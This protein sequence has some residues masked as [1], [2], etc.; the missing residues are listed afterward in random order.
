MQDIIAYISEVN[1]YKIL[2]RNKVKMP[3]IK[4]SIFPRTCNR[5]IQIRDLINNEVGLRYLG[6]TELVNECR[7]K[8][9][10][11]DDKNE[12]V[13]GRA[14]TAATAHMALCDGDRT[15]IKY[16]TWLQSGVALVPVQNQWGGKLAGAWHAHHR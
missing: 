4:I 9:E 2:P 13:G 14:I 8:F 5:K 12:M 1:G 10:L 7:R 16:P 3:F 15:K 11:A 6:C